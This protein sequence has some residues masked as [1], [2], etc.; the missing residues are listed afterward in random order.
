MRIQNIAICFVLVLVLLSFI[1]V[2]SA[3][4][5]S[6]GNSRMVIRADPEEPVERYILVKNVNE[7]PVTIEFLVSGTLRDYT[8][9]DEDSFVLQAGEEKKA[10]FTI[11]SPEAGTSETK[12]VVRFIPE[13][14]NSVGLSSTVIFIAGGS[15]ESLDGKYGTEADSEDIAPDN[16]ENTEDTTPVDNEDNSD[17]SD[18]EDNNTSGFTFKPKPTT[19]KQLEDL[20]K[21]ASDDSSS[22]FTFPSLS[23][24]LILTLSTLLL[25]VVLIVLTLGYLKRRNGRNS[26]VQPQ[27]EMKIKPKKSVRKNA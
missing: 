20:S 22:S 26:L 14:G 27:T 10:Y 12:I 3:T 5:A 18:S 7:F 25:V 15:S 6:I 16:A 8:E 2:V 11:E 24:A 1:S 4:T 13:E 23:P 17:N 9:L 21:D 19:T